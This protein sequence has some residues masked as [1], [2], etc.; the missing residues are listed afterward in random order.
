MCFAVGM[1]E[2]LWLTTCYYLKLSLILLYVG[3]KKTRSACSALLVLFVPLLIT[4]PAQN[5]SGA[6]GT[7]RKIV[8]IC[9]LGGRRTAAPTGVGG[10]VVFFF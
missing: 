10:S 2:I 5:S 3:H 6:S 1:Q 4:V 9:F 8:A 7:R